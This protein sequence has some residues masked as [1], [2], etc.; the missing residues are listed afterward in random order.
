MPK[1]YYGRETVADTKIFSNWRLH[2]LSYLFRVPVSTLSQIIPETCL[3]L[4]LCLKEDYLKVGYTHFI[5]I[6]FKHNYNFLFFSQ[7]SDIKN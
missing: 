3:A 1:H 6:S 5:C 7:I 2:S 4:Y